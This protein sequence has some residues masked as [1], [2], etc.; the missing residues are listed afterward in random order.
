M[1]RLDDFGLSLKRRKE[2]AKET[3]GCEQLAAAGLVAACG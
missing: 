3:L 2:M 1:C